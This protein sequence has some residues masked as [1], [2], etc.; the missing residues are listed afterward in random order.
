MFTG[1]IQGQAILANKIEDLNTFSIKT[2]L[3]LSDCKIGSSI[4]C[5]GVCLTM[6]TINQ[7]NDDFIFTAN[8]GEETFKRTNLINW[9][10]YRKNR[11]STDPNS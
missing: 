5:D 9:K 11:T 3:D 1:I 7:L 8:V 6:T 2:D 4:S 10:K